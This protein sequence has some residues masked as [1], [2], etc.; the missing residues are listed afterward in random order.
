MDQ[1]Q[2]N[3]QGVAADE[4]LVDILTA[5]SVVSMRLARKLT[6]LAG[7]RQ[8]TEGGKTDEQNERNGRN[9]RRPTQMRCHY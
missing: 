1:T 6:L 2:T 9:H 5:I 8:S 3:P 4:E 7:Q